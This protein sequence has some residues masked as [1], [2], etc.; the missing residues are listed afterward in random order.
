MAAV[1]VKISPDHIYATVSMDT[2]CQDK[3]VKVC[4]L[5][6]YST[7]GNYFYTQACHRI[8]YLIGG[9]QVQIIEYPLQLKLLFESFHKHS[10][11]IYVKPGVNMN[12]D[13]FRLRKDGSDSNRTGSEM[14]EC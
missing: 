3:Y 14:C 6:A 5:I 10:K 9:H 4:A 2:Y 8:E 11:M 7:N 13:Y 1:N 12:K